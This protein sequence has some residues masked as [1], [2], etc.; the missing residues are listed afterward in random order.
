MDTSYD[1]VDEAQQHKFLRDCAYLIFVGNAKT[2][3]VRVLMA[4]VP[5]GSISLIF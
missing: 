2:I 1:Q 3:T 4:P 5:N